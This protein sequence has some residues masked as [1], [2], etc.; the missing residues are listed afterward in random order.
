MQNA[1]G[2]I[3]VYNL[4]PPRQPNKDKKGSVPQLNGPPTLIS[5]HAKSQFQIENKRLKVETKKQKSKDHSNDQNPESNDN[6]YPTIN[7]IKNL[8]NLGSD[9]LEEFQFD[10]SM[11]SD[12]LE[13]LLMT[14]L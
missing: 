5:T 2:P 8:H 11:L 4:T 12:F 9:I 7:V 6:R 14:L 1:N 10:K 13:Q 3:R